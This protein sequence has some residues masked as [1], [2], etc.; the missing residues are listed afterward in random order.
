M[1]SEVEQR[2][3]VARFMGE[4]FAECEEHL[5][6]VRGSLL[7]LEQNVGRPPPPLLDDLFRNFHS[8]KGISAIADIREGE[9]LAH[10]MESYL[11]VLR[12]DAAA[13]TP[14]GLDALVDGTQVF[15]A[16]V[17]AKRANIA[18]PA[19]APAIERLSAAARSRDED[20]WT[21]AIPAASTGARRWTVTFTPSPELVA[22]GVK[23]DGIR[24]RLLDVGAIE[25]V[26]PRV[27]DAGR[28]AFVFVVTTD[29]EAALRSWAEDGITVE[30]PTDTVA[31]GADAP[32]AVDVPA[33]TA[34]YVRVDLARLDDLMRH[35][36]DMVVTRSR[37][38]DVLQR[39]EPAIP[40]TQWRALA[41][42]SER[43]ERQLRDLR[44]GVMRVRLVPV[45]ELFRRMPF[46][47]RD[48]AR[49]GGKRVQILLAGQ[50][51]EIDKFL[52]ERMVDPV[53]HLVRNAVSHG[54]EAP[55]RRIA[56]GKSPEGQIRLTATPVGEAVVLE[57]DDDG[58]GLDRAEIL[59][60]AAAAGHELPGEGGLDDRQLL[61]IICAPGF[62]TR[63]RADRGSGRGVGMAVVRDTVHEL[64]GTLAV[65]SEPGRGT[66][67][68]ITLP[69]TLAI[70]DALLVTVGTHHFAV[71][72]SAVQEVIEVDPAAVTALEGS[73]LIVYRGGTLPIVRLSRLFQLSPAAD[74]PRLHALV[75]GSG[76]GIVG[77]LVDR[78]IG[79][80]EIV[81]KT[82]ADPL[83]KVDG[84]TGVTELGDG[85]VI[86]ILDAGWLGQQVRG[87][88]AG[89][90]AAGQGARA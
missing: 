25:T 38:A 66:T 7:R 90:H 46:V 50:D 64:G 70:A 43:L 14:A 71:P 76:A 28:I 40:A 9:R 44:E 78:I 79:Q 41:E 87:R 61:D 49:D 3:F 89:R 69:L 24:Q 52:I 84:V 51:T 77:L 32:I 75:V 18:L 83:I 13:L 88:A 11:R 55:D 39:A 57:I 59:R 36:G 56:A 33:S 65:S 34:N 6:E 73:E 68:R 85:R 31:R 37:L 23:V 58:V 4:Y 22:R 62:S 16:L 80:R 82:I 12:D 2:D 54:I 8:L 27:L 21:A 10:E 19:I 5:A 29:N 81:V 42:H 72:Q 45:R 74:R 26:T 63:D 17:A 30:A 60:R 20:G 15:E 1:S 47:V 67:Y 86:L 35:V 48:L 53:L